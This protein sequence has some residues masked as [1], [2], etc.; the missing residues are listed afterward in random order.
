M[1]RVQYAA[2]RG[3]FELTQWLR[4]KRGSE[5]ITVLPAL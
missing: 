2:R 4:R 3:T 5:P 1:G